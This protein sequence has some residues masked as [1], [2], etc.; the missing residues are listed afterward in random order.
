MS[1]FLKSVHFQLVLNNKQIASPI[2]NH[3]DQKSQWKVKFRT[4]VNIIK[5][6][7]SIFINVHLRNRFN[8][9][10]G[11]S[12]GHHFEHRNHY[13]FQIVKFFFEIKMK[14]V[15][16]FSGSRNVHSFNTFL[17]VW[18]FWFKWIGDFF[19]LPIILIL[20]RNFTWNPLWNF[21]EHSVEN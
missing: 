12:C 14:S 17:S 15:E 13:G 2:Q 8:F 18:S 16:V 20:K 10:P 6:L 1:Q 5:S 9:Q 7:L 4:I 3:H 11:W 19:F 21:V